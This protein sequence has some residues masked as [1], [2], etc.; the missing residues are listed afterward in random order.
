MA[1]KREL[2]KN[3][4]YLI[5]EVISDCFTYMLI[6]GDKK[7]DEAIAI[8]ESILDKR[9]ELVHRIKHQVPND[10]PKAVKAHYRDIRKDSLQIIDESFTKLS[11]LSKK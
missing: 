9:F 7:R 10:N 8:I 11:E 5:S 2:K 4:D 6:N 1:S 3:I